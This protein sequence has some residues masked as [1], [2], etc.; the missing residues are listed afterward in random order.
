M[1]GSMI[2]DAFAVDAVLV[3]DTIYRIHVR[4]GVR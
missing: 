3:L 2:R 4:P 1:M